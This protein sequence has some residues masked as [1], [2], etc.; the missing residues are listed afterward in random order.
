MQR[1]IT[2]LE[3]SSI[4]VDGLKPTGR[5]M[6]NTK[7]RKFFMVVEGTGVAIS[8]TQWKF[9]GEQKL[10]Q[11]HGLPKT[12]DLLEDRL[13]DGKWQPVCY[14]DI[15]FIDIPAK[16]ISPFSVTELIVEIS[17]SGRFPVV[18][19]TDGLRI[20]AYEI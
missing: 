12:A 19:T 14:K 16:S 1:E 20:Q 10:Y 18:P 7:W 4:L 8:S 5:H 6:S 3:P 9:V 11:W 13:E 15:E 2:T 17:A